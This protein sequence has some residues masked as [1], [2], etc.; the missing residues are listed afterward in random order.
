[1]RVEESDLSKAVEAGIISDEQSKRLWDMLADGDEHAQRFN[2]I[3]VTYYFGALLVI[4]AMGWFITDAW[5]NL[6]GLA[7]FLIA[8][9]YIAVFSATGMFLWQRPQDQ[10]PGGLLVTIA[11]SLVPLAVYGIQR[12]LDLWGFDSPG[13]YTDFHRWIRGGWFAMELATILAGLLAIRFVRF[14]F[15]TAPIF[16]VLWYMSMDLTPIV[17]GSDQ[18]FAWELRKQVSMWFGLGML[19]LSYLIDR[20]AAKDF[21][22]W[23]YLFGAMAFW[24]GLSLQQSDSE[25]VKFFYF[26]INLTMILASVYLRRRVFIVFGALGV[27]GYIG[28]LSRSV[29]SD[30][31]LFPIALTIVGI[32]MIY[33]GVLLKRHS[34]AINSAFDQAL[35]PW[36]AA[37]RPT[38]P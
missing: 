28:H 17:A 10:V 8:I 21:A 24:G 12:W 37:I 11:V 14:P 20:F 35:P 9:A 19:I 7:I 27:F 26:L 13:Q 22:F 30:S 32:G 16:L 36:L 18:G 15:L 29:F 23:G 38:G 25:L 31:L 34:Q 5:E 6:G 2:L 33:A 4:A 1:M 3:H